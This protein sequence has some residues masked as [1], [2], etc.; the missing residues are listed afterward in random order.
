MRSISELAQNRAGSQKA[1]V[2]S[3]DT[4]YRVFL[5]DDQPIAL[6]GLVKV[7]NAMPDC[8]VCGTATD[9]GSA[10]EQIRTLAPDLI[11]LNL[12]LKGKSGLELVRKVQAFKSRPRTLIFS[13]H[14]ER[15][16][17]SRALRAGA[18]GFVMKQESMATLE[19]ALRK[20]LDGGIYLSARLQQRGLQRVRKEEAQPADRLETLTNRELH[21]FRLIGQGKPSQEIARLLALSVKTVGSHRSNMRR[22]LCL[23]TGSQLVQQAIEMNRE[24]VREENLSEPDST[25]RNV[26]GLD[27]TAASVRCLEQFSCYGG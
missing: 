7:V 22:K 2:R 16:Y 21:I 14:D 3:G 20:V 15:L 10:L 11:V 19:A 26:V 17:A 13:I 24:Y 6:V 12:D 9:F 4:I 5:A 1:A 18:S 25:P 23:E 27:S 8:Q